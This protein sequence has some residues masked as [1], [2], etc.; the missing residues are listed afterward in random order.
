LLSVTDQ[1]VITNVGRIAL[2]I[3][4]I[5]ITLRSFF[6]FAPALLLLSLVY[7]HLYLRRVWEGAARLPDGTTVGERTS[8]RIMTALI[9]CY[10][11]LENGDARPAPAHHAWLA[12]CAL[13]MSERRGRMVQS[14]CPAAHL[15]H[16]LQTLLRRPTI[17]LA[18]LA[19]MQHRLGHAVHRDVLRKEY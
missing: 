7:L 12:A 14:L 4:N 3:L 6:F 9:D 10:P 13:R 15:Q 1:Q 8:P 19:C 5:E 18:S 16:V 17:H 11:A 2:P